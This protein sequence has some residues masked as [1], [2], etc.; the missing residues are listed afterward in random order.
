MLRK[1]ARALLSP[2]LVVLIAFALVLPFAQ[3]SVLNGGGSVPP[4][5]LFPAGLQIAMIT[6]TITAP[7]F[8]TDYTEWVL[9]DPNNNWCVNC[10]DFVF[11]FTNNGP[12]VNERYSM[13]SYAGFQVDVGTNPFGLNDPNTVNRSLGA[14]AV[15]GFNYTPGIEIQPGVTTPLLVIETDALYYTFGWVSAQDGTASSEIAY[16]PSLV[17]EPGTVLLLGSGVIGLAGILRRKIN[18]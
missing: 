2:K 9:R 11:Q 13:S 16:A 8:S 3:A 14:G 17:P 12:D 10:L 15:I 18:L 1:F 5:P 7:T 4:S 6:G